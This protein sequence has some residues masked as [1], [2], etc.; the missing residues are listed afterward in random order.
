MK[1]SVKNIVATQPLK[2]L[3]MYGWPVQCLPQIVKPSTPA[4]G[5]AAAAAKPRADW[6]AIK[7]GVGVEWV[8][9]AAARPAR[10]ASR[11]RQPSG[12]GKRRTSR[13]IP[14]N[15]SENCR[16]KLNTWPKLVTK[17]RCHASTQLRSSL[18]AGLARGR[19][20]AAV[21]NVLHI[22]DD[23]ARGDLDPARHQ[24]ARTLHVQSGRF[25]VRRGF[26]VHASG[27]EGVE[28]AGGISPE[29]LHRAPSVSMAMARR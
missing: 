2:Q 23:G 21:V 24:P 28:G 22:Y 9:A 15:C 29:G 1:N 8:G 16:A 4:S 5:A 3:S 17:T 7:Y 12:E 27:A 13:K 25:G 18:P 6:S 11:S 19:V 10:S 20:N 14:Q 26:H